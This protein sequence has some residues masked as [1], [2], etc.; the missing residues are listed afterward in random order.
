MG[1]A[2]YR[3]IASGH[4]HD[5]LQRNEYK[6]MKRRIDGNI[7]EE[8]LELPVGEDLTKVA[9]PTIHW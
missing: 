6:H 8:L 7:A 5:R 9:T 2:S 1:N 3:H 4:W